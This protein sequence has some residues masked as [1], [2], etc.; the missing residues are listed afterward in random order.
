MYISTRW[1]N[2]GDIKRLTV[3]K[4][5]S[6]KSE[7]AQARLQM[8]LFASEACRSFQVTSQA[9]FLALC[10]PTFPSLFLI[11]ALPPEFILHFLALKVRCFR[12]PHVTY[13]LSLIFVF[14]PQIESYKTL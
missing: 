7:A 11:Q 4:R 2:E 10:T 3:N 8:Y 6:T 13:L 12:F 9:A 5:Y 14:C 1:V